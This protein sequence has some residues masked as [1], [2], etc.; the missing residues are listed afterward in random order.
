[1]PKIVYDKKL[2]KELKKEAIRKLDVFDIQD[3]FTIKIKNPDNDWIAQ[4]RGLSQ[5]MN[6]GRG[7]IFWLAPTLI[8]HPDEFILSILHEY[9]HVIA[10][11]AWATKNKK[12]SKLLSKYY[13]GTFG[14]RPWDEEEFAEDFAQGVFGNTFA[15]CFA[16]QKICKEYVKVYEISLQNIPLI[17]LCDL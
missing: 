11:F 9:G 8:H 4:Y 6:G 2:V 14:S 5:F 15:N 13:P 17:Y 1:M 7:P 10:E 3:T 12:I 16:I